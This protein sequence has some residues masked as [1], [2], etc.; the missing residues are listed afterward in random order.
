MNIA[1]GLQVH[2]TVPSFI[3]RHDDPGVTSVPIRDLP[4]SETTLVW[5]TTNRSQKTSAFARAA[6][7]VLAAQ[8]QRNTTLARPTEVAR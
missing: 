2:P 4:P 7:D 5:L 3:E 1:L 8:R 6:D